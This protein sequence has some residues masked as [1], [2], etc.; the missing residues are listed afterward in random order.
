MDLCTELKPTDHPCPLPAGPETISQR[1]EIPDIPVHGLIT[2][3][4][5]L[6]DTDGAEITCIVLK[7]RV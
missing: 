2:V 7:A 6:S 3:N 4:G 1:L 5:E